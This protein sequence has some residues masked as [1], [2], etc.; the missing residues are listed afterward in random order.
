VDCGNGR[1]VG[2]TDL[3][4]DTGLGAAIWGSLGIDGG[5]ESVISSSVTFCCEKRD[6]V[7]RD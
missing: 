7:D 3:E 1:K 6:E 4:V 5:L 2:L